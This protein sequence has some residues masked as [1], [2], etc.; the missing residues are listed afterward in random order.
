M[1]P[2]EYLTACSFLIAGFWA[3]CVLFRWDPRPPDRD[4]WGR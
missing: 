4:G 2:R 1:T 3:A